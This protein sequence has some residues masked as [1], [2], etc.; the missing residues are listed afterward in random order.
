MQNHSTNCQRYLPR[1][2]RNLRAKTCFRS[3]FL[4]PPEMHFHQKMDRMWIVPQI[5][6]PS[7]LVSCSSC[8]GF[9]NST[10]PPLTQRRPVCQHIQSKYPQIVISKVK[11]KPLPLVSRYF[12][13]PILIC[14]PSSSPA[15]SSSSS[16]AS[17]ESPPPLSHR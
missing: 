12:P 11:K 3:E 10:A 4:Y 9:A 17:P 13:T 7:G 6:S 8:S 15:S 1:W 14:P 2:G 5:P 16:P